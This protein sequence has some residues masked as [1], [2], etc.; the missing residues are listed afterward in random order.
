[1]PIWRRQRRAP[2][3]HGRAIATE[4]DHVVMAHRPRLSGSA[5]PVLRHQFRF[6]PSLPPGF[7]GDAALFPA[8]R[9]P[10]QTRVGILR[11]RACRQ[12]SDRRLQ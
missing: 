3:S 6:F 10:G 2:G 9:R 7:D 12:F 8:E 4:L 5:V 1:M 11:H